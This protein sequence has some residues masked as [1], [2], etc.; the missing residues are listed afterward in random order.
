VPY[1]HYYLDTY[2]PLGTIMDRWAKARAAAAAVEEDAP[3]LG[4]RKA[5]APPEPKKPS[6]LLSLEHVIVQASLRQRLRP[7]RCGRCALTR[8]HAVCHTASCARHRAAARHRAGAAVDL[9]AALLVDARGGVVVGG[10]PHRFP[11]NPPPWQPPHLQGRARIQ[12][13]R[14]DHQCR[15]SV[16]QYHYFVYQCRYSG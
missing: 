6:L 1:D 4:A 11:H 7:H 16:Y 15:C 2:Q 10:F 3:P 14:C 13:V 12:R 9:R 8:A 5:D